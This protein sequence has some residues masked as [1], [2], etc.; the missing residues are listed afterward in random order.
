MPKTYR[1]PEPSSSPLPWFRFY[2]EFV[3]DPVIRL[4]SFEDQR[5]FVAVLCL[6]CGGILDKAYADVQTR[7][8]AIGLS[9]D[10]DPEAVPDVLMRL[11]NAGLLHEDWQ[12]VA[13]EKRQLR[14]DHS[15]NRVRRLRKRGRHTSVT[16]TGKTRYRNGLDLDV[17]VDVEKRKKR[18]EKKES[19][20]LAP[21]DFIATAPP[22]PPHTLLPLVN[23]T[24]HP[25][26]T[27]TVGELVKLYPAVDVPGQLLA[28][29]GWL[30]G[31][32]KNRKTPSGVMR[33]VHAWLAKEQNRARTNGTAPGPSESGR[34]EVFKRDPAEP[35]PTPP[36]WDGLE[37]DPDED[38]RR[39]ARILRGLK[40]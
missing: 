37:S 14:S 12:P 27:G 22:D 6:K 4:L 36:D 25:L 7:D 15:R 9:L 3:F 16:V 31:N 10:L 40:P 18:E 19:K 17:D 34:L 2:H 5:H 21:S 30:L 13:W 11:V 1:K 32:P 29:R 39:G 20:T 8:S 28:M 33:F 23:G 35:P 24:E 26:T 38:V